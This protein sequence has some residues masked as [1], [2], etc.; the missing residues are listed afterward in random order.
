MNRML[1]SMYRIYSEANAGRA[2]ITATS[3]DSKINLVR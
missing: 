2:S 3:V 1:V